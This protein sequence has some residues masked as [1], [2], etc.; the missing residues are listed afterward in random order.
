MGSGWISPIE[1]LKY[2]RQILRPDADPVILEGNPSRAFV[3]TCYSYLHHPAFRAVAHGIFQQIEPYQL[4][5]L[6]IGPQKHLAIGGK[7]NTSMPGLRQIAD[8]LYSFFAGRGDIDELKVPPKGPVG[9]LFSAS[10]PQHPLQ[11]PL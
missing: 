8:S 5:V 4:Q 11:Q 9:P 2:M 6:W 3:F 7:F 10:Q 1:S